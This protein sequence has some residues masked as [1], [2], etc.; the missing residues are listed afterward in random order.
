MNR[1]T[2]LERAADGLRRVAATIAREVRHGWDADFT[3][4][5]GLALELARQ[6]D[7]LAATLAE[8]DAVL[9]RALNARPRR[10]SD[11]IEALSP[12]RRAAGGA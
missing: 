9:V 11:M 2:E 8:I 3:L 5:A 10:R 6:A 4:L 7:R 12:S 1:L